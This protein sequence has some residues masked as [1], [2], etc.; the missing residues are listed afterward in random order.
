MKRTFHKL[1]ASRL[2]SVMAIALGAV[3]L[4]ACGQG[5]VATPE[6]VSEVEQGLC[7]NDVHCDYYT[8]DTYT[9]EC[10]YRDMCINCSAANAASGCVTSPYRQCFVMAECSLAPTPDDM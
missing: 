2:P 4:L 7:A 3:F 5:E 10:G 8:D 6:Q 9:V 1:I